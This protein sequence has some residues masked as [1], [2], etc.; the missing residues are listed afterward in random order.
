M[1]K[2]I[3]RCWIDLETTGL[4]AYRHGI[5]QIGVILE[6]V[7]PIT[8]NASLEEWTTLVQPDKSCR[9]EDKAL[10]VSGVTRE[11][12]ETAPHERDVK[13][14]FEALLS[15]YVDKFDKTSKAFFCGY[16]ATFDNNFV[17]E[18]WKRCFDDYFGSW[19]WSGTID[20]MS[21]SLDAL[22]ATRWEMPDFKLETVARH[23]LGEDEFNYVVGEGA[24]HDAMTDIRLT[25][26][27]Y[28]RL[29]GL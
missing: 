21:L 22:Q 4:Q 7:N 12:M 26:A 16:N 13:K 1:S 15:K 5:C 14:Q 9:I 29:K 18:W 27:I 8:G 6:E 20:A 23:V 17:R 24:T 10:E 19:F 2:P 28:Q 25:R 11:M 3:V